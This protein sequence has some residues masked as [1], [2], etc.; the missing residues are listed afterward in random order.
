MVETLSRMIEIPALGP[1]SGGDGEG[2][3][4][5]F[6]RALLESI[7]VGPIELY[8]SLDDRVL[9]NKR[10]NI[11]AWLKKETSESTTPRL[12]FVSHM[13]VVPSG[14]R[15]LWDSEPFRAR[16]EN[17]MVFG[18]G[19]EDNGQ[20][21]VASIYAAKALIDLGLR[22]SMD[23]GLVFVSDEEVGAGHG[24]EHLLEKGLFKPDDLILVPDH[25][26]PDGRLVDISEKGLGWI[27]VRT[28]GKQCHASMPDL[29]AN[30]FRAAIHFA[31][32]VEEEFR[33]AFNAEDQLFDRP[34]STLEPT[35]KEGNIPNINTVPGEDVF[36]FDCRLIPPYK[37]DQVIE[38]LRPVADKIE[39]EH[40]VEIHLELVLKDDAAPPTQQDAPIV[41][42]LLRSIQKVY[43]N[44]PHVGGIGGGTCAALFRREGLQVA[45]WETADNMAHAP[46]EYSKIDNLVGDCKVFADLMLSVGGG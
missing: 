13:D 2:E 34:Y 31:Y 29:G 42:R 25:G 30:A 14:D 19:A 5:G 28:I 3:K 32:L 12:F 27:K 8:E 46:N 11:I 24:I 1:E 15:E 38:T 35:K 44:K 45:V 17:E 4:A 36:Y 33:H 26:T 6:I 23:V 40:K 7:D 9:D 37:L 41:Q 10:P 18:R 20:S 21:L 39:E 22:P 16:V 43:N